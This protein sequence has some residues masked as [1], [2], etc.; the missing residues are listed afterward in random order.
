MI[1]LGLGVLWILF[2]DRLVHNITTDKTFLLMLNTYKGVAYVVITGAILYLLL[3]SLLIKAEQ[4][5]KENLY[6][7]YHDALTGVYNRRYYEME[8]RRMDVPENLPISVIMVDVNGLKLV[9]DAF[10]HQLGDQLLQKSAQIIKSAC[11]P[12]DILARWGGDEFVI[13]LPNTPCEEARRLTEQIRSFCA[14]ES[15]DVIQVSM[16]MGCAVKE[17]MDVSFEEV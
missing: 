15:Y 12:Q 13:L 3:R 2:S 8:V 5:E 16:S 17:S 9:N 10:G 6:L 7:S 14:P 11:R 4:A 1:Y